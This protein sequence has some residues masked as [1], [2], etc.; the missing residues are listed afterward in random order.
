MKSAEIAINGV[1]MMQRIMALADIGSTG[2]GGSCRLALTEE[3]RVGRDL[4][5]SWMK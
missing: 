1:R 3:D 4:V 2:D 5:V